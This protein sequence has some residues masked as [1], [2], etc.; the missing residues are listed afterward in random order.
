MVK[1]KFLFYFFIYFIF[2]L[3]FLAKNLNIPIFCVFTKIDLVSKKE[4]L[5]IFRK[6]KILLR[7][8]NINK[9]AIVVENNEDIILL[10]RNL[11]EKIIPTFFISNTTG[12]GKNL[13]VSFLNNIP[14][15]NKEKINLNEKVQFD[16]HEA[17]EM[18]NKIIFTGI[19]VNGRLLT[20][21]KY[22]LGPDQ[23][24]EFK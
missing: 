4:L 10:N 16:I 8:L 17:F 9:N 5:E 7:F 22:F 3:I 21:N 20:E 23:N 11:D 14:V 24:G 13:L 19:L 18:D 6:F 1:K 12:E 15:K 2:L